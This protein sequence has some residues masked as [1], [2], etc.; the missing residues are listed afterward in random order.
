M[1]SVSLT[2]AQSGISG[3]WYNTEKTGKIEI[4][5]IKNIFYGKIVWLKEPISEITGKN[6][7]DENN[8]DESKRTKPIIGLVVLK[9]F[10]HDGDNS[11]TGGTI[12]DPENGKTYK[13]KMK[14]KDTNN[15]DVRGY[16]G[17]PA[18]GRTEKW[19]RSR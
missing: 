8:P 13:C 11:Y 7:V 10:T 18:L 12:Y 4:Y 16:I 15:L 9:N 1:L 5:Q 17:I 19:T 14:L 6:K 3:I 2:L